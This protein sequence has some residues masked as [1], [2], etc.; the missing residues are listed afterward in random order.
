MRATFKGQ[1]RAEHTRKEEGGTNQDR[2]TRTWTGRSQVERLGESDV[3]PRRAR[4]TLAKR[5]RTVA[6]EKVEDQAIWP[7]SWAAEVCL[8]ERRVSG[9]VRPAVVPT[10]TSP[11]VAGH[12]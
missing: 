9:V 6:K 8:T 11:R 10:S 4:P 12:R 7:G 2:C 1:S 3:P 5:P